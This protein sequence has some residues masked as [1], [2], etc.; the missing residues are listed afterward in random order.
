MLVH[1]FDNL[2][3]AEPFR[4]FRVHTAGGKSILVTAP[5]YAWHAPTTRTVFI[6]G[7]SGSKKRVHIVDLHLIARFDVEVGDIEGGGGNGRPQDSESQ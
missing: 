3:E 4:P 5:E 1:E 6:A 7:T 2:M